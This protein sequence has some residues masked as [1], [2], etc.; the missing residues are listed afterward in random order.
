MDVSVIADKAFERRDNATAVKYYRALAKGAPEKSVAY[1]KLCSSYL[2][3]GD[4]RAALASCREAL[5]RDGVR[6]LDH[7]RFLRLLVESKETLSPEDLADVDAIFTHLKSEKVDMVMLDQLRCDVALRVEDA[8]R[9][10]EC[11]QAL[12]AKAPDDPRTISYQWS[13]AIL[14]KD[15][16]AAENLLERARRTTMK[17]AGIRKMEAATFGLKQAER[18]PAGKYLW[19]VSLGLIAGVVAVS[20]LYF[21]RRFR[22]AS[23]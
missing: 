10:E 8:R 2:A 1:T 23:V 4:V 3:L 21:I 15:A 5:R 14:R 7:A 9:L 17:E 12:V 6:V 22:A 20:A 19:I 11:T 13:L 16:V 18:Q